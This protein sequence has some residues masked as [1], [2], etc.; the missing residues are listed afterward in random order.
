[1]SDVSTISKLIWIR[2]TCGN[3]LESHL[4]RPH[5]LDVLIHS[6]GLGLYKA[7]G[8]SGDQAGWGAK[9]TPKTAKK[10]D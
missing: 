7:S 1:M 4:P 6:M 2:I 3:F 10:A 5:P 9:K 8:D